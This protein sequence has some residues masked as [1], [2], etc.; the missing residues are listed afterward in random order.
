MTLFYYLVLN[1]LK[2]FCLK[3]IIMFYKNVLN[4][5]YQIYKI[6]LIFII[7]IINI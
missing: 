3:Y 1:T 7:N 4:S 5:E 2:I 6:L